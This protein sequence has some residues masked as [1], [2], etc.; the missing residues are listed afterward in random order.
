M[1]QSGTEIVLHRAG[2]VL[3]VM[4]DR[5]D[6]KNALTAAMYTALAQALEEAQDDPTVR[7]VVFRG[8]EQVFTSGNDLSD[9]LHHPPKDENS[10]VF[11][12]LRALVH[13]D[14]PLL[15]AVAGPAVGIGA[16]M[17]LHC[18]M[19]I[20]AST[21]RFAMPFTRLGLCPEAAS[22]LLL[23]RLAGHQRAAEILLLGDP[24]DAE[25]A[26]QMGV[27]NRIVA[28]ELLF[29]TA[30]ALADRLA[31]LPAES[32]R[33]TRRLLKQET[34]ETVARRIEEEAHQFRKLLESAEAKKAFQDFL[35][36]RPPDT[37][38]SPQ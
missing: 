1:A 27:V 5:P 30:A 37:R 35:E 17:L 18:D 3:T 14:K 31:E 25:E 32:L 6:K 19:V 10:P 2:A 28:P 34:R 38:A 12:F 33:V 22:S 8:S 9:F 20:A 11:R 15:A 26:R 24:F 7:V 13:A 23:P 36:R 21:A 4:L 29:S 16:T